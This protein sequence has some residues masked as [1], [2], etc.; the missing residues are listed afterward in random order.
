MV[1]FH[2]T[3]T[4]SVLPLEFAADGELKTI[5]L[6][7]QLTVSG[8]ETLLEAARKGLGIVQVP[9][10][11]VASDIA[12]GSMVAILSSTPP[13]S[14]LVHVLYP[15][16]KQPSLRV[17]VFLQWIADL[18]RAIGPE[19][20]EALGGGCLRVDRRPTSAQ[21]GHSGRLVPSVPEGC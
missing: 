11:A 10:Y 18:H 1:G 17:R 12:A 5:A 14:M 4:G 13:P 6:P 16:T 19:S 15:D 2:S 8:A 21:S 3:A 20:Q 7:T 9:Y